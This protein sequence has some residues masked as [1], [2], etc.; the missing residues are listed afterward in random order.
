MGVLFKKDDEYMGQMKEVAYERE[1]L[2]QAILIARMEAEHEALPASYAESLETNKG[3]RAQIGA[4]IASFEAVNSP[5]AR[6]TERALYFV[7]GVSASLFAA[8]LWWAAANL[9]PTLKT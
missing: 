6:N 3:L 5:T 2:E 8:A 7:L 1:Q 4:L 9:W